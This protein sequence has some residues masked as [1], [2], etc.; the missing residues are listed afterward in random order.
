[1]AM[2]AQSA[3][4]Q[5]LG[6]RTPPYLRPE[7]PPSSRQALVIVRRVPASG[8]VIPDQSHRRDE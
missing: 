4:S 2:A 8:A 1:M 3:H 5:H 7:P 6:P